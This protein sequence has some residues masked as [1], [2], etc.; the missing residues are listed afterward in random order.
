MKTLMLAVLLLVANPVQAEDYDS[1][2]NG[3]ALIRPCESKSEHAR[4]TCNAYIAGIHDLHDTFVR[5]GDIQK[6]WCVPKYM[7]LDQLQ[8]F[9]LKELLAYP[10]E[11]H[12]GAFS[13]VANAL[14]RAFPCE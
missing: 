13:Y 12:K 9:V 2:I 3:N 1:F 8:Y 10:G 4:N 6:L 14:I 11:L 7:T 5:W